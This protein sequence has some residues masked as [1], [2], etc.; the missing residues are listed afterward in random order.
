MKIPKNLGSLLLAIFLIL[1]G[2]VELFKLSF[3]GLSVVMGILA[4]VAGLLFLLQR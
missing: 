4:I 2:L 3:P 1:Y